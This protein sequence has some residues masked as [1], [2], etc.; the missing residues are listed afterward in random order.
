M[1]SIMIDAFDYK[2]TFLR[3]VNLEGFY[4]PC[5]LFMDILDAGRVFILTLHWGQ[6]IAGH[7]FKSQ[8]ASNFYPLIQQLF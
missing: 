8:P 7:F 1:S 2:E 5:Y 6:E 3:G 4:W